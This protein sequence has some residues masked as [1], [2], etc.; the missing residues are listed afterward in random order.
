MTTRAK[1]IPIGIPKGGTGKSTFCELLSV[2]A[3]HRG[4][5][6][7]LIDCDSETENTTIFVENRAE[8]NETLAKEG[9]GGVPELDCISCG[10]DQESIVSDILRTHAKDYDYIFI[11]NHPKAD[12]VFRRLCT[13]S[14]LLILPIEYTD[15]S[16]DTL[17]KVVSMLEDIDA[18]IKANDPNVPDDYQIPTLMVLNKVLTVRA[19]AIEEAK[20]LIKGFD[21]RLL[22][23]KTILPSRTIYQQTSRGLTVSDTLEHKKAALEVKA[24]FTEIVKLLAE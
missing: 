9:K 15:K 4:S 1:I 19:K 11:D 18:S 3:A 22:I 10:F 21:E 7:L 12:R 8:L 6:V 17:P 2:E 20:S 5:K 14:D 16:F 24:L 23:A 13:I